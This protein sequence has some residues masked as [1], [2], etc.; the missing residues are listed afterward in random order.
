[1]ELPPRRTALKEATSQAHAALDAMVGNFKTLDDYKRYLT[2]IATFRLPVEAWLS[3]TDLP[4]ELDGYQPHMVQSELEAD[5]ADLDTARPKNQPAFHPPEG[6][7]VVGLL[8]VLEGSS[9]GARL[10]AK[11][12]EALGLSAEFGARH[13]F[14]QARNFSSWRAFSDRM[15]NVRVYDDQAAA[16]WANTAF[17]YARSAFESA[18]NA[19]CSDRRPHQL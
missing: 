7:G 14:S 15:E 18:L 4:A 11:R 10:L 13:L 5:L 12:A 17:D 8:Y 1:M 2:G 19:N 6:E 9:L 3:Q 16:R